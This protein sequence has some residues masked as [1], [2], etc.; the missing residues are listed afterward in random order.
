MS[1]KDQM[2]KIWSTD[3]TY[4]ITSPNLTKREY[5]AGLAM[6][7]MLARDPDLLPEIAADDAVLHADALISALSAEGISPKGEV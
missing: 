7:G 4:T 6:Q 3:R 5:F 2:E 1:I